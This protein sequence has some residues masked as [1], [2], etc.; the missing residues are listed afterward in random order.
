MICSQVSAFESAEKR[1]DIAAAKAR[2]PPAEA[3]DA[4]YSSSAVGD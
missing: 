1:A 2:A 3:D 4:L